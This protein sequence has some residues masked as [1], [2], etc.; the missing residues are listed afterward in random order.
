V[1]LV[2]GRLGHTVVVEVEQTKCGGGCYEL[3]YGQ[4]FDWGYKFLNKDNDAC[5][6][7]RCDL[8]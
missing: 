7:C 8:N 1:D 3:S 2:S 6:N 4:E 5:W